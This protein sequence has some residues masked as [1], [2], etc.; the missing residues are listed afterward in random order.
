MGS[1][2]NRNYWGGE[3]V[4]C[5]QEVSESPHMKQLGVGSGSSSWFLPKPPRGA[6]SGGGKV[7]EEEGK[8][9]EGKAERLVGS[10]SCS[11]Q[12]LPPTG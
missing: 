10:R 3:G 2:P 12:S 1:F 7:G 6:K 4:R 8:R 11:I 5:A 9:E